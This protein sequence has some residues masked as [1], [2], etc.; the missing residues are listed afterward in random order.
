M[1]IQYSR[2]AYFTLIEL[3]VVIAIIAILASMLLP[4]LGAARATAKGIN[5][6][7]N[8]KQ[9]GIAVVAYEGDYNGWMPTASYGDTGIGCFWKYY[10]APYIVPGFNEKT[11]I[12]A[13]YGDW[14]WTKTF[15]CAEFETVISSPGYGGGYAWCIGMGSSESSTIAPRRN[16][17]RLRYLSESVCIGDS[18]DSGLYSIIDPPS[19][20][21]ANSPVHTQR[22][23]KGTNILWGDFHASWMPLTIMLGGKSG[24]GMAATDYYYWI[25]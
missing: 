16:A 20:N 7:S 6:I 9:Q 21:S 17:G 10:L 2:K 18:P 15:K 3:L 11:N 19:W 22:H 4:A 25:K 14:M 24:F 12:G 8:L 1:N 13:Y 5:C 23:K